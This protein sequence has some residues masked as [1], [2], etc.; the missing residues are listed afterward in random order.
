MTYEISP[1]AKSALYLES[2]PMFNRGAVRLPR[3]DQLLRELRGLERRVSR[4]GKDSV[5]HPRAGS[6]DLANA[7][8]GAM[9][10]AMS[11][12]RKPGI[13]VGTC[14]TGGRVS[15]SVKNNPDLEPQTLRVR[16]VT[17]NADGTES[18]QFHVLHRDPK[19]MTGG[20]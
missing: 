3:L 10:S 14:G 2:L 12:L 17:V 15:Y 8:C 13:L 11:G 1:L 4:L 6:D 20:R 9:Y 16:Y 7:V 18:E 5:D 19:F